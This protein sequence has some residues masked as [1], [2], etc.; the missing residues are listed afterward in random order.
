[1]LGRLPRIRTAGR[2]RLTKK[3]T[4]LVVAAALLTLTG[5]GVP[6][7]AEATGGSAATTG[8]TPADPPATQI[9]HVI[10]IMIE[11]HTFDNLFGSFPGADG[12]PAGTSMLNPN[13]YYDSAQ[14]VHNR[15]PP[16]GVAA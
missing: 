10:E 14:D 12:I 2:P 3:A 8:A 13:A 5:V 15:R 4:W 16:W 7:A 1:M 11:N 6:V 9:K